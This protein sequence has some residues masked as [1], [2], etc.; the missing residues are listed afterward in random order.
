MWPNTDSHHLSWDLE[1]TGKEFGWPPLGKPGG[2]FPLPHWQCELKVDKESHALKNQKKLCDWDPRWMTVGRHSWIFTERRWS[3]PKQSMFIWT[4]PDSEKHLDRVSDGGLLKYIEIQIS[5][6]VIGGTPMALYRLCRC[7]STW[8]YYL[9]Q[10]T[11]LQFRSF[12]E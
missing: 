5:W 2:C 11:K 7:E 3:T 4:W 6:N 9:Q 8:I 10:R 12:L 1:S